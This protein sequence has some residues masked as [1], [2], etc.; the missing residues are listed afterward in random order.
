MYRFILGRIRADS[1]WHNSEVHQLEDHIG[2]VHQDAD[3]LAE[4]EEVPT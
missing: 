2:S 4:L 1:P 3:I